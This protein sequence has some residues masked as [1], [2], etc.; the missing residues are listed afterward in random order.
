[1][2]KRVRSPNYP[3]ISLPDA[4]DKV[5]ALYKSQHT[6][7]GP[8]EVIVRGMGYSSLN[9]ASMS[10][11]SALHKYGLLEGRGDEIRVSERAMRIL[12]PESQEEHALAIQ[13]AASEPNL[14]AELDER[15]PGV[16]PN[17]ELLRN[18]LLRRKFAPGAV[19]VA[20]LA[21]RETKELVQAESSG[22]D[23]PISAIEGQDEMHPQRGTAQTPASAAI[24]GMMPQN[25]QDE[26]SIGRYDFEGGG[27]IRILTGGDIATEE[28]LDMAETIISMKRNEIERRKKAAPV[29]SEAEDDISD[30]NIESEENA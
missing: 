18:Y 3:A 16:V 5:S 8:R 30:P 17:E 13:E 1:M 6:H 28:A 22:Y 9:G 12:H 24:P 25:Q 14:F 4:L 11:I 23:S 29:V 20:I 27:Y 2:G 7:A 21:Y 19:S 15:F 10:A 26:R